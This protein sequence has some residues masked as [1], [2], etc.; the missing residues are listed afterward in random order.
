MLPMRESF[1]LLSVQKE[2]IQLTND[3]GMRH[4]LVVPN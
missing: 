3:P 4:T 2:Q 1:A